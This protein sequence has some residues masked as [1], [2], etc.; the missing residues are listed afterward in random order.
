MCHTGLEKN[1]PSKS[2][3]IEGTFN[4]TRPPESLKVAVDVSIRK[5]LLLKQ[6]YTHTHNKRK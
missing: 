5:I 1:H 2:Q 3:V 6:T 4:N